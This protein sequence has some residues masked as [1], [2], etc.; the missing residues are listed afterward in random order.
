M[1]AIA[2]VDDERQ[3]LDFGGH[4][5]RL[6]QWLWQS[7]AAVIAVIIDG[8]GEGHGQHGHGLMSGGA[9]CGRLAGSGHQG[10]GRAILL[11]AGAR[12][13]QD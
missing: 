13:A 12:H 7:S 8:C 10:T 3:P 2:A 4:L 9:Q 6:W 1:I 11:D 5:H